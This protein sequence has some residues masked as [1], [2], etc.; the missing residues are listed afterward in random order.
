M[1]NL[2]ERL[3]TSPL[4]RS[5][6][7]QDRLALAAES[8]GIG[9]WEYDPKAEAMV[10]DVQMYRL[11]GRPVSS[12]GEPYDHWLRQ[13]HPED[14]DAVAEAMAEALREKRIAGAGLDVWEPEPPSPDHPLLKFDNVLVS[15][16][17]AGVTHESRT[18]ITTIA[19][20]QLL[21]AFDGQRPPRLLNPEAWPKFRE[22][23]ARIF[24]REAAAV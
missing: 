11:H 8:G 12:G 9:V 21:A 14:H 15:P 23:Y 4:F 19:V 22:R 7:P 24:G 1:D 3:R 17:T 16:H 6:S 13:L 5:L 18:K 10:W 2:A 20:E